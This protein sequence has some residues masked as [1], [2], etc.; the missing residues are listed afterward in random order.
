MTLNQ[1]TFAA[2]L[3]KADSATLALQE[4]VVSTGAPRYEVQD[5]VMQAIAGTACYR[6]RQANKQGHRA[7]TVDQS[8]PKG[9]AMLNRMEYLMRLI[10]Q[11]PS[12]KA[13][14]RDDLPKAAK[15]AAWAKKL[16]TS[17]IKARIKALE[18]ELSKR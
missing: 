5:A 13:K 3:N 7:L 17:D 1:A 16:D 6:S 9:K 14:S 8:T 11:V 15:L 12:I 4:Y 18:R 2:L 10:Y